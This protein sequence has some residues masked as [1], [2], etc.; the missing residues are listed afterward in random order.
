VTRPPLVQQAP[1][2]RE[3]HWNFEGSAAVVTGAGSGIGRAIALAFASA[4][5]KVAVADL[6]AGAVEETVALVDERVKRAAIGVVGDVSRPESAKS[7]VEKAVEA[8]G[9]IDCAV[10]SAGISGPRD[11]AADIAEAD[12]DRVIAINLTG[13]WLSMKHQISQFMK[14]RSKASIVNIS[15]TAGLRGYEGSSAYAASK[16]GVVGLTRSAAREYAQH[17]IRINAISPGYIRTPMTATYFVGHSDIEQRLIATHPAGRGGEA[18]EVAAV[19]LWLCSG[20]AEY[21]H[22]VIVPVD[23]G[24]L[25]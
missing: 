21:V 13:V 6:N 11:S 2:A 18:E 16:H 3:A 5:A 17:G 4:G 24:H 14:Q 9:R 8:F 15:S 12:W 22:G 7:L 23:G 20:A 19:A 10:N 1:A 25:A